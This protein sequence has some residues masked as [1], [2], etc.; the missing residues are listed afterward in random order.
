MLILEDGGADYLKVDPDGY[1][2]TVRDHK[3]HRMV[4]KMMSHQEA[5]ERFV[6]EGREI[7]VVNAQSAI[8]DYDKWQSLYKKLIVDRSQN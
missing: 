8:D 5:I 3:P 4:S 6:R 2:A 1:R 7:A